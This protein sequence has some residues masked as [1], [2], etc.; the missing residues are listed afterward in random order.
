MPKRPKQKFFEISPRYPKLSGVTFRR[1]IQGPKNKIQEDRTY[2]FREFFTKNK[3]D[4][5]IIETKGV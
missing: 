2:S 1:I 3:I 4:P 5:K